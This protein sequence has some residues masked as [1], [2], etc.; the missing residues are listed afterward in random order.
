MLTYILTMIGELRD[1]RLKLHVSKEVLTIAQQ[2]RRR[3]EKVVQCTTIEWNRL[4]LRQLVLKTVDSQ[5]TR[6][7]E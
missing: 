1:Y 4:V 6:I 5:D 7:R 3:L 2:L